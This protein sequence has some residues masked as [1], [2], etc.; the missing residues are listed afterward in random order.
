[1]KSSLRPLLTLLIHDTRDLAAEVADA[2]V[3]TAPRRAGGRR[4]RILRAIP[5]DLAD[6]TASLSHLC[7]AL[8]YL[9]EE[10]LFAES[11]EVDDLVLDRWLQD[12]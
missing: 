9:P 7:D 5:G 8:E 2:T 10:T 11:E 1:M 6:I 4:A 12:N 3:R